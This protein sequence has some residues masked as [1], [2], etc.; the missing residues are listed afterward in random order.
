ML[1]SSIIVYE[2][3][4]RQGSTVEAKERDN[5][6]AFLRTYESQNHD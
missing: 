5:N 1:Y 3:S 6:L 4:E 2:I